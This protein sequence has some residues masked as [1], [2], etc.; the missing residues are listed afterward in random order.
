[1][2]K[3]KGLVMPAVLVQLLTE[4]AFT[5]QSVLIWII[6]YV[7]TQIRYR[8]S[9]TIVAR[10]RSFKFVNKTFVS[11]IVCFGSVI[12]MSFHM[13]SKAKCS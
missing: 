3:P 6:N 4:S 12:S 8:I 10:Q 13:L 11:R 7:V 1:M 2:G 9:K 5:P